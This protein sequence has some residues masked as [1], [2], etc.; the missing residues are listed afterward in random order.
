MPEV[1]VQKWEESERGWGVRPDGYSLHKDEAARSRF[2]RA[3]WDTMP[4]ETPD[5]YSRPAGK[6]YMA[7][8]TP[9]EYAALRP[10]GD[11]Y[12]SNDYPGSGGTDGWKNAM[13]GSDSH[14]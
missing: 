7:E 12:W 5:E 14:V 6:P 13:A 11:R 4:K 2:I 1:V 9:E 10:D 8:V 3:Y